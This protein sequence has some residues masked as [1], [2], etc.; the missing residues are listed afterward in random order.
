MKFFTCI[1]MVLIC[2]CGFSQ[3]QNSN[4]KTKK[5]AVKDS[6]QIDSVSI[7]PHFFSI[8]RKDK[9]L[10]DST[11]YSVDFAKAILTFKKTIETDSII[12]N[13]L[14]FPEFLTKT[15]KQ[16]DNNIIVENSSN[17]QTLYK[18]TQSNTDRNF[19]PFEGLIRYLKP[20]FDYFQ[21]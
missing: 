6:I 15:Y 16:L 8:K 5:V 3:S 11:Y 21:L 19:I 14:K 2:F 20:N 17:S 1:L 9:T 7:N 10:I 12:I 13:Y 18:L 4:Y